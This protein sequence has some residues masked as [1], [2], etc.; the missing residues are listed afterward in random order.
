MKGAKHKFGSASKVFSLL[1]LDFYGNSAEKA[2][3]LEFVCRISQVHT[4]RQQ[5]S[6]K[7]VSLDNLI[8]RFVQ[9][10]AVHTPVLASNKQK[11]VRFVY[12]D[13][14]NSMNFADLSLVSRALSKKAPLERQ[15]QQRAIQIANANNAK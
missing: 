8:V 7:K 11:K 6:E 10:A 14:N 13:I 9:I 3:V 4:K 15:Q 2:I 1:P 12:G 5:R